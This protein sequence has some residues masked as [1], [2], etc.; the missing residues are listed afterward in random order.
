MSIRD[1]PLRITNIT[2]SFSVGRKLDFEALQAKFGSKL[3]PAKSHFPRLTWRLHFGNTGMIYQSGKIVIVGSRNHLAAEEAAH[4]LYDV[5]EGVGGLSLNHSN[6]AGTTDFKHNIDLHRL[7]TYLRTTLKEQRRYGNVRSYDAELFPALFYEC[8]KGGK[9]TPPTKATIFRTG[10]VIYS[11]VRNMDQLND[12]NKEI[13]Y[14]LRSFQNHDDDPDF[15]FN[16]EVESL[17]KLLGF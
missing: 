1:F 15:Q 9:D 6:I 11:G 17:N 16:S 7:F 8:P 12:A 2:T 14:V 4:F 5:L 10:K 13:Y 3:K